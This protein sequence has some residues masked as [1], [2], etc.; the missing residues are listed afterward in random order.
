[1]SHTIAMSIE[2]KILSPSDIQ[3]IDYENTRPMMYYHKA[4][5]MRISRN[6]PWNAWVAVSM[7]GA[8]SSRGGMA[9]RH[10]GRLTQR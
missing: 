2:E 8:L 5:L 1:M 9:T 6:A 4:D 10:Q 7:G 3:Y